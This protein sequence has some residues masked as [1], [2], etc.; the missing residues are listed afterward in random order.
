[1]KDEIREPVRPEPFVWVKTKDG[2]TWLCPK[3]SLKDP[4]SISEEE[5]KE[6]V[7]DW[8]NPQV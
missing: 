6:C 5:L 4:K 3:S 7:E 8:Q 2:N 1:M